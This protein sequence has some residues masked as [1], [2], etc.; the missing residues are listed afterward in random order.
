[1]ARGQKPALT[2]EVAEKY[3][4][5]VNL[6]AAG[7]TFDQIA[8]RVGYASRSGAKE[9]YDAALRWWGREAV[10]DMRVVEGER[11]ERMWREIFARIIDSPDID[12]LVSLVNTGVRISSRR[13]AL[14]G[15]DVPKAVEVT[16]AYGGPI[17]VD[18]SKVLV[19]RIRALALVEAPADIE[20]EVVEDET[21]DGQTLAS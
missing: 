19:E 6:K 21:D 14:F 13:S 8:E 2:P 20:G 1:M 9:A 18:M 3:R 16:G 4:Q 10:D 17:E 15:L 7:A 5:V 12:D 11:L